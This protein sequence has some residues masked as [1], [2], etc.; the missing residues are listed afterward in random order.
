MSQT[1]F[2]AS[3]EQAR[4]HAAHPL[5]PRFK[6]GIARLTMTLVVA[7]GALLAAAYVPTLL[8]YEANIVLSGSMG[9]A[10]PIGAVAQTRMVDA[11]SLAVGDV[12]TFRFPGRPLSVT[13]RIIAIE[14]DGAR[15]VAHTK[16]DANGAADPE[17]VVLGMTVA[18]VERVIPLA[19]YLVRAVRTP[20]GM[21]VF[22]GFPLL[23]LT[24]DR[25]AKR[26]GDGHAR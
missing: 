6:T 7:V 24:V 8:G 11:R 9:R 5:L 16:G 19:G 18:R 10:L 13:H 2:V 23:A 15:V 12:I 17:P 22:L 4:G 1:S 3:F 20:A 25:P 26:R 14:N 21:A